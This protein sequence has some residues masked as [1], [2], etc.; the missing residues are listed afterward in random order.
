MT[1]QSDFH[2]PL[3]GWYIASPA[4]EARASRQ[5]I[6]NLVFGVLL[7]ALFVVALLLMVAATVWVSSHPLAL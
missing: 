2:D 3:A 4:D 7:G 1:P 5:W 6:G